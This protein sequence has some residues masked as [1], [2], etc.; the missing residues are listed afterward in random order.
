MHI[1]NHCGSP[2][3][4][5]NDCPH[6]SARLA[7]SPKPVL[8]GAAALLGLSLTACTG[9]GEP[10]ALYGAPD[11]GWIDSD[12]DGTRDRQDCAPEDAEVYPGAPETADD[13][14]DSNCDGED[15]T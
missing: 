3:P 6:C 11:S 8:L 9:I 7:S 5:G 12:G 4:A 2:A 15:N 14:V 13:G 1:C 10:A